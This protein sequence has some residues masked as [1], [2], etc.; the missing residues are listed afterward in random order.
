MN[1]GNMALFSCP[2]T[3][4]G[5][6]GAGGSTAARPADV[7]PRGS[8]ASRVFVLIA[9]ALW[10]PAIAAARETAAETPA[11]PLP[12]PPPAFDARSLVRI[13]AD[14]L[15]E[16]TIAQGVIIQSGGMVLAPGEVLAE[17]RPLF[18]RLDDGS[19]VSVTHVVGRSAEV[20]LALLRINRN[21]LEAARLG[22]SE[23]AR[24]LD[25]MNRAELDDSGALS[26]R[27]VTLAGHFAL[28]SDILFQF[29]EDEPA[30]R[31]GAVY[32]NRR[33]EVL[34]I[35][36]H[37][38]AGRV[39]GGV[40]VNAASR[41]NT[42][43]SHARAWPGDAP[44]IGWSP[45]GAAEFPSASPASAGLPAEKDFAEAVKL[46]NEGVRLFGEGKVDAAA[47][48][49]QQALTLDSDLAAAEFNLGA[50]AYERN[51]QDD[52]ANVL[53]GIA[54]RRP[55]N[56]EARFRL[57]EL[58][59]ERGAIDQVAARHRELRQ[60]DP[61]CRRPSLPPL[62]LQKPERGLVIPFQPRLGRVEECLQFEDAVARVELL[63]TRLG[64][65]VEI[66]GGQFP[67]T[68]TALVPGVPAFYFFSR[69]PPYRVFAWASI[70]Q[71]VAAY[72]FLI[73][74]GAE[75]T[76]ERFDWKLISGFVL[77]GLGIAGGATT[78]I[79]A[80]VHDARQ[81]ADREEWRR[82]L[83]DAARELRRPTSPAHPVRSEMT[84]FWIALP[85][86]T[87]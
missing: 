62:A 42:D 11:R 34:A 75:S 59:R 29:S 28:G 13:C 51:Q 32:L 69:S 16:R 76:P 24:P 4:P 80:A 56:R 23:R 87:W 7:F 10:A 27:P 38:F 81:Q 50:A 36:T 3:A 83:E 86:W 84:P 78:D 79:T 5:R 52:A 67:A 49:F 77:W 48:Y 63:E 58:Q 64:E 57:Y 1:I 14:P 68:V 44:E 39:S 70:P 37:A 55:E 21:G 33:G 40:P 82:G 43:M 18:A 15:C 2:F 54:Q 20:S 41:L 53:W 45:G 74:G 22:D 25:A 61:L 30:T 47:R 8:R 17:R 72:V 85:A 66:W 65:P 46:N 6:K 12:A 26:W 35:S 9:L 73:W 60:M 19:T 71:S 31:P